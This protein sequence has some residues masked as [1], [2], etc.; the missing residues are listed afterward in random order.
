MGARPHGDPPL[1]RR[2]TGSCGWGREGGAARG[3]LWLK[4]PR[5]S[6]ASN[7]TVTKV[8]N[9]DDSR[10]QKSLKRARIDHQ[11]TSCHFNQYHHFTVLGSSH[12]GLR[13]LPAMSS[14][15]CT[16]GSTALPVPSRQGTAH[17]SHEMTA[18]HQTVHWS[19]CQ[20]NWGA[21]RREQRYELHANMDD[22]SYLEYPLLLPPPPPQ[23]TP[24]VD[25]RPPTVAIACLSFCQ[26]QLR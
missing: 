26:R 12:R 17:S 21:R 14:Y 11:F 9:R 2:C 7:A 4:E 23:P 18:I 19:R 6:L 1:E 16:W 25:A 8:L 3:T 15:C 20:L 5:M 22:D 24:T 13:S 10:S